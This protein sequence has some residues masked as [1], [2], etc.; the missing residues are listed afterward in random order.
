MYRKERQT[1]AL[2]QRT[3][4]AQNLCNNKFPEYKTGVPLEV[5]NSLPL[6]GE[7]MK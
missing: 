1:K 5:L 2:L 4:Q 7:A 3:L 6:T